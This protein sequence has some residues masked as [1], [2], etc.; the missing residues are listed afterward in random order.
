MNLKQAIS[1][2]LGNPAAVAVLGVGSELRGDDVAG[3]LVAESLHKSSPKINKKIKFKVFLGGTAPENFTGGIKEFNP[4]HLIIV[5]TAE[6]GLRAGAVTV[7]DPDETANVSF[8]TH[9][10]PLKI[11]SD[12]LRAYINCSIIIIGIQPK[13][14]K[15]GELPTKEVKQAIA[16]VSD[17]LKEILHCKSCR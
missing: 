14:M 8:S 4:S 15:F 16:R 11:M 9:S 13:S 10:L 6:A 3:M 1:K 2:K 12:Y 17:A 7:F 5:D